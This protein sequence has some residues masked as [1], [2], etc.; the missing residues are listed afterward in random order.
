VTET[1]CQCCKKYGDDSLNVQRCL[2]DRFHNGRKSIED[3]E[4]CGRPMSIYTE[5]NINAV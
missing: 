3:D 5:D 4:C 2:Y 1:L